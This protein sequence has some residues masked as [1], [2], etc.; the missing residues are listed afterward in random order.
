MR[1]ATQYETDIINFRQ[2]TNDKNFLQLR[3][4][5]NHTLI[6]EKMVNNSETIL[7]AE[8]AK[9]GE[10]P[11]AIYDLDNPPSYHVFEALAGSKNIPEEI[12]GNSVF[13]LQLL[14]FNSVYGAMLI[15]GFGAQNRIGLRR[16]FNSE[17]WSEWH[18]VSL[19]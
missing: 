8:Y 6:L 16:K 13:V 10:V 11:S 12:G 14:P 7:L 18:Y 5:S 4:D 9:R 2:V 1:L 15:F 19:T 3:T 17:T